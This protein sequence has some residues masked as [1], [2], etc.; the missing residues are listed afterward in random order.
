[1]SLTG[2]KTWTRNNGIALALAVIFIA[3]NQY[4]G[5]TSCKSGQPVNLLIVWLLGSLLALS[6]LPAA[7][8]GA[9]FGMQS[10]S[11]VILS[12]LTGGLIGFLLGMLIQRKIRDEADRFLFFLILMANS[13]ICGSGALLFYC[14][15][16]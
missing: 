5:S 11:A 2:A 3:A 16:N 8:L 12:S 7:I 1:M 14:M 13:L 10:G 4:L 15:S 9:M 6:N